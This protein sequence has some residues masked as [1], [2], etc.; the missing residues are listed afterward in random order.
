MS[1]SSGPA[2]AAAPPKAFESRALAR[3]RCPSPS[4]I[5]AGGWT[6]EEPS[7]SSAPARYPNRSRFSATK[8][9][10]SPVLPAAAS[11]AA[12]EPVRTAFPLADDGERK[13]RGEA[14]TGVKIR[15]LSPNFYS[16]GRGGITSQGRPL[17]RPLAARRGVLRTP[18]WEGPFRAPRWDSEGPAL[19]G[20]RS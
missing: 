3:L 7:F 1:F 6:S 2:R 11:A 4:R 14:K 10:E 13:R 5:S 15:A 9:A 20:P 18:S 19:A 17:G 12:A 8:S 16:R